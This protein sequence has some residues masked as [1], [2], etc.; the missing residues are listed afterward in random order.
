MPRTFTGTS[1]FMK[2]TGVPFSTVGTLGIWRN[3]A[4]IAQQASQYLMINDGTLTNRNMLGTD[5]TSTSGKTAAVQA[6][7]SGNGQALSTVAATANTWQLDLAVFGSYPN[8]RTAYLAGTNKAINTGI[9]NPSGLTSVEIGGRG[10]QQLAHAFILARGLADIE[11]AYLGA[12][13]NPQ[14]LGLSNYYYINQP[15]T[16]PDLVGSINLTVTGAT[17]GSSD[18]NIATWF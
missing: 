14:A 17:A 16:E 11:A 1:Q 7:S 4:S 15:T 13:G 8:N 6:N 12:G 2:G 3:V 18:P 9:T 5:I 10:T